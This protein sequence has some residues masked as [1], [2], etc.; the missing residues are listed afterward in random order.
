VK[1]FAKRRGKKE[2][3]S[4]SIYIYAC[5]GQKVAEFVKNRPRFLIFYRNAKNQEWMEQCKTHFDKNR[6][7]QNQ[8]FKD[9]IVCNYL[10]RKNLD[11]KFHLIRI[12]FSPF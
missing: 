8:D 1:S 3:F 10:K 5:F 4:H 9:G 7:G 6:P 12:C 2:R 11:K